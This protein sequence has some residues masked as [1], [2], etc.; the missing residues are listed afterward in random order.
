[1]SDSGGTF[2]G[3]PYL[4]TGTVT[5][6]SGTPAATL[7]GVGLTF[8]YYSG[9]TTTGTPLPGAPTSAGTYTV[10]GSFP[11]SLDYAPASGSTTFTITQVPAGVAVSDSGGTFTGNPYLAT[12]T[13]TGISGTPAATLDGVGLTFT[14]YAGSTA[15]GTPLSGAPSSAGTYTVVATYSGSMDY[16]GSSAQTTFTIGQARPTVAVT[17]VGGTYNG[18]PYPATGTVAGL[19]GVPGATLETVG[20]TYAHYSGT[21]ASGTPL[22]G[23][24]TN[25]GTYTV[26]ASFAGSTDYSAG[27]AQTTFTI[28]QA[29]PHVVTTDASGQFTGNPFPAST[30][31]T[32]VGNQFLGG[33]LYFAFY[34]GSTPTGSASSTAPESVG[35]YTVVVT[36]VTGDPDYSTASSAPV[37]FSIT[38]AP[39]TVTV[40]DVGGTYTGNAFPATSTVAGLSGV[41]GSTLEGVGLTFTYYSGGTATGTP[42]AGAPASAGTY[43]F[44]ASFPGSVDY[45]AGSA[46]TTFT[47]GHATSQVAVNDAGGTYNGNTFPANG[48][49]AG[50][51]GTSA[52]TLEGVGLTDTYYAGSTATGTPLPGAPSNAGTYT[53]VAAFAGSTNYSGNSAQ[54]TFTI[55]QATPKVVA[56]DAGGTFT[57]NPFP[58]TATATGVG[59]AAVSGT[60]AY[61]NYVGSTVSGTG[62]SMAPSAAGTYTV[63]AAFTSSNANYVGASSLPVTFTITPAPQMVT[64]PATASV[65]EN[66]SLIFSS[67]N[68]NAISV[69]DSTAGTASEQLSLS[70]TNGTLTLAATKG[71]TITAGKNASAS[72][73][74]KGTL[75]NINA[76]LN[77]LKFTPTTGY[78]GSAPLSVAYKNLSSSKTASATVAVSVV[79][80][81]SQPT[82]TLKA[83]LTTV[84]PGQ[85]VP[86]GLLVSD[87]NATAQAAKFTYSLTF[88][89]GAKASPSAANQVLVN[90]VY[91]NTGTFT[92]NV[93]AT[94]E[95]GHASTTSVV[96]NVVPVAVEVDP[97]SS[98]KTAIYVGGTSGNDTVNFALSGS[99][100]IAVTLNGVN[101]GVYSTNGPLIIFGQGGKDTDKLGT[102]LKNTVYLLASPNTDSA[103]T[104]LDKEAIQ[105]AGLAAAV[106]ILNE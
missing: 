89:D 44:V 48:T 3:N 23:A 59:G 78:S 62:S 76:A 61:T 102:G 19:N 10:V 103:E 46:Q 52:S 33:G 97:F 38:A 73:T 98:T 42:L 27:S 99:S 87:T 43:T 49:V 64:A 101:E 94:D 70:I 93:T 58:A 32:G 90:H 47:I 24:P 96:I 1:V 60:F 37:T 55:G 95:F 65:S 17:D 50:L 22:S 7:E 84:V 72:M 14:Y 28:G 100:N 20:L 5:G 86:L 79:V 11:G 54:T 77:G 74:I 88:G 83:M 57:G 4:A 105:W 36:F 106:Q 53:V 13:V 2:T 9:S 104:D 30:T 35:T 92:V 16:S 15:T 12:G 21:T 31:V 85:P 41:P 82:L 18:N 39:A 80:P 91:T 75:A 29:A 67:A 66:A 56:T 26:V 6:I 25:A 81:A 34:N 68:G 71:L 63:V 8:T 45:S 40:S 69:S 51:S